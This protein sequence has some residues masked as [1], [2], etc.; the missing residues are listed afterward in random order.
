MRTLKLSILGTLAVAFVLLATDVLDF[1][2]VAE[3]GTVSWSPA[4]RTRA[5]RK[6]GIALWDAGRD[7]LAPPAHAATA[8]ET[9]AAPR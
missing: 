7:A 9:G 1:C 8:A 6:Y 4:V 5:I 3:D 2:T